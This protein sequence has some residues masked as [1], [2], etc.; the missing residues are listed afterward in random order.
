MSR[1]IP[2]ILESNKETQCNW[3]TVGF[4]LIAHFFAGAT[5]FYIAAI[6]FRIRALAF[7]QKVWIFTAIVA[8]ITTFIFYVGCH[9][10]VPRATVLG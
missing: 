8:V 5:L 2:V 3:L 4:K 10:V 9:R 7:V 1:Y 6:W